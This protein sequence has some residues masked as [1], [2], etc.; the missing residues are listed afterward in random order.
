MPQIGALTSFSANTLA[1]ASQVNSNFDTIVTAVNTYCAFLD[2]S[3]QT[4]T[5][6][7]TINPSAGVAL[8]IVDGGQT[9]TAGNLLL[10]S[11]NITLTSGNLVITSGN[12]TLTSG[13]LT[14]TSGN[15]VMTSGNFSM[16]A[17]QAA[18]KYYNAGDSGAAL[19]INWNNGQEQRVRLTASGPTLTLTNPVAGTYYVLGLVQDT[20]GSRLMPTIS[21]TP[22]YDGGV[23]PTLTTTASRKDKLILFYNGTDYELTVGALNLNTTN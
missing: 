20:N 21:P 16:G 5:G 7:Q 23:T 2:A 8:T 14:L 15:L 3:A 12:A 10:S 1:Q 18:L 17:G 9:I 4:F 19:T 6:N 13:S 22:K 11:G